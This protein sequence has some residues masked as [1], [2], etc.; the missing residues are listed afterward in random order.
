[1]PQPDA[2]SISAIIAAARQAN[3]TALADTLA[4]PGATAALASL[5]HS[6]LGDDA[7]LAQDIAAEIAKGG[8]N[9]GQRLQEA[10][11]RYL[12][13]LTQADPSIGD[14]AVLFPVGRTLTTAD[15]DNTKDARS[16]QIASHDLTNQW[17]AYGVSGGFLAIILLVLFAPLNT[18]P[19][20]ELL[21]TLIGVV[22]TGWANIIGFYFGSSAGS[23][24]KS[25]AMGEA[26]NQSIKQQGS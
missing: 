9:L 2:A 13:R 21:Y 4:G 6:L 12:I 22:A 5:G 15:L 18:S 26:L 7:A 3:A 8:D 10:E 23:L 25:Q 1:M 11:Q 19:L 24:Q 17:L 16:R 20:K 14:I